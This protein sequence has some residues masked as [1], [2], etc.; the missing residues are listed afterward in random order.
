MLAD[1]AVWVA[2]ADGALAGF[3][4]FANG[5]VNQLYVDPAFQ[6]QGVGRAL[7]AIAQREE[8]PLRLWAFA[9]N[10]P[11]ITFYERR[12]FRI[13]ERTDGAGNEARQPDVLMEWSSTTVRSSSPA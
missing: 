9:A 12:G 5:W 10:T 11:A 4:A 3:I 8:S 7:L 1:N 13:I 2:E 6:G